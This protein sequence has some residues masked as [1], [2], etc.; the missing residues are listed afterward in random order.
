MRVCVIGAG[1]FGSLA[2]L[3]LAGA[4]HDVDLVDRGDDVLSAA[5]KH[6]QNRIHYG[7]H[8]PRSVETARES[9][10]GL[11]SFLAFFQSAIC[12]EFSNYYGVASEH[13][14]STPEDFEQFCHAAKLD[15]RREY[16]APELLDRR[17]LAACYRVQEPVFDYFTAR[18]LVREQLAGS[19]VMYHPRTEVTRI[20]RGAD[21]FKIQNSSFVRDYDAVVNCTYS[22]LNRIDA[23]VGVPPKMYLYEDVVIPIFEY[24]HPMIGLTIMD[25][26]FCSAMPRGSRANEFLLYHVRH[27]IIARNL[28]QEPPA[29][30]AGPVDETRI[31]NEAAVFMPFLKQVPH[32][33]QY[34]TMRVVRENDD[35]ARPSVLSHEIPNYWSVLSGKV[36]TCVSIADELVGRIGA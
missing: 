5:S 6:N 24:E 29:E 33:G 19:T 22:D 4:G 10:A 25:G 21:T 18:A 28:G 31:F 2:A 32:I 14:K 11:I 15:Y 27:S 8:Y 13:S 26:D 17:W 23:M 7:Y 12:T 20:E 35:D 9:Q 16:P 30:I 1:F 34:R 3:R 36:T